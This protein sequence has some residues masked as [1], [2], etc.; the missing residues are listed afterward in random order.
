MSHGS[1]HVHQNRLLR[2]FLPPLD[3]SPCSYV[4]GNGFCDMVDPINE[5]AFCIPISSMTVEKHNAAE[6]LFYKHLSGLIIQA[7]TAKMVFLDRSKTSACE[8]RIQPAPCL[9]ARTPG[10]K[11][12]CQGGCRGQPG[13]SILKEDLSSPASIQFLS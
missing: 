6:S 7:P 13:G 5:F 3:G 8:T 4:N 2:L 9:Y 11:P 1:P 10:I 12:D